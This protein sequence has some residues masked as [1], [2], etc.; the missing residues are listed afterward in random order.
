MKSVSKAAACRVLGTSDETVVI[1]ERLG[2]SP[3]GALKCTAA[4]RLQ[5]SPLGNFGCVGSCPGVRPSGGR[6]VKSL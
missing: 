1:A 5:L 3:A 4:V 2:T 6:R